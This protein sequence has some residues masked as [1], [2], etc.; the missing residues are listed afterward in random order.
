ML[1]FD[2]R[3]AGRTGKELPCLVWGIVV[4]SWGFRRMTAL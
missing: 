1:N 3:D 2:R 4:L